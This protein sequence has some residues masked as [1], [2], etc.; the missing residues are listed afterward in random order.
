MIIFPVTVTVANGNMMNV[1]VVSI[2]KFPIIVTYPPV[3][4][5]TV[6]DFNMTKPKSNIYNR[7]FM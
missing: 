5:P 7:V 4:F 2:F 6:P 1:E 3:A